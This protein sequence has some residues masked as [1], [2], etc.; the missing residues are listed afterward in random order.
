MP[1][2]RPAKTKA[3]EFV[4]NAINRKG[5]CIDFREEKY[6]TKTSSSKE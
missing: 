1:K 5:N 4:H 6:L 2:E 3:R